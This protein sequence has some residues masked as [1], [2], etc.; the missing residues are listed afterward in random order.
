MRTITLLLLALPSLLKAQE[1]PKKATTITVF[2][3]DKDHTLLD[4]LS[5]VLFDRGYTID[6][7]DEK[8]R[9]IV[10]KGRASKKFGTL[11]RLRARVTDSTIVFTS[12]VAIA[13]GPREDYID[14]SYSGAK[15]G[16]MREA[17]NEMDEI[18]RTFG[19]KLAY[20]KK[21]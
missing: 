21:Q 11:T 7:K 17:W 14:V 1:P 2:V 8:A 19:D 15:K 18:A 16:P 4:K 6:N 9:Y 12:E 10:T 5:S 13:Y 20:S 3:T